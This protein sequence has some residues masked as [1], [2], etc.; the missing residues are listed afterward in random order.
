MVWKRW[1]PPLVLL[2]LF[3]LLVVRL[4]Q[5]DKVAL[6]SREGQTFEKGVV[7]EILQDNVQPDGSRV[8]EQVV[9]VLMKTGELKG[10]EIET[11]SSSGFLFGAPCTVGMKV[12]VM[13]SLAGDTVVSS[14]YAQDREFQILAFAALY[15]LA[16]CLIG[17]WQGAKGALG[18]VFTFGCILWVYLPLV[19]RGWSPFW[20]AVLVCAVTAIVTLWLVGGPTRKTLVAA[21]GTVAGV[22]MAGV[23]ASLFSLATGITGWNVSDIES[24][25]TLWSTADIQV[26]GLLF[27]GLLISSLGATMDVAMS[28]AS[29]MAEVQA[30][31]P[32]ISRRA[33]FQAGMRVGR[34]MMGTDSNT[35]I[36][37]FAG[38]S[39]S[40]LVLDYA[41]DLPWLQIINSNNIGIAVMQGLAG[42][43]GVVLSV[44]VTVALAMLLYVRPDRETPALLEQE[45]A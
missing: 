1:A 12:V 15:L 8:G 33:L 32:D 40:M 31:T 43:F 2:A 38:G 21:A 28:I 41:Y 3:L 34:D 24:L 37:A 11:T 44:P 7:T 17:G 30:Q 26:G 27:S 16:L 6:V 23:A 29:S 18:L 25:M 42:S 20:S 5:V 10:R 14:V 9:R 45:Q 22:V 13:Q 4:N 35:L 36:L 19:Y 39:V